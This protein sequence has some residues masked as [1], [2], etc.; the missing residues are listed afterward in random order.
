MSSLEVYDIVE[1]I[2]AFKNKVAEK[3]EQNKKERFAKREMKKAIAEQER[4]E[5][6]KLKKKLI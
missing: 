2:R 4:I 1:F 5:R 3:H 6:Q